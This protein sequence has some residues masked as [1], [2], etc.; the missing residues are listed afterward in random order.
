MY[1]KKFFDNRPTSFKRASKRSFNSKK[2]YSFVLCQT[3]TFVFFPF[4]NVIVSSV[5]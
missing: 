5:W 4:G 3:K 1:E 2:D